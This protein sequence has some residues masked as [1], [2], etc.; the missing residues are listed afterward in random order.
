MHMTK[1]HIAKRS[2]FYLIQK[3]VG[4][5]LENIQVTRK[6]GQ[7]LLASE[8]KIKLQF[9]SLKLFYGAAEIYARL[10]NGGQEHR[11]MSAGGK[12]KS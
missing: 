1:S 11:N 4:T 6:D 2:L 8:C 3:L 5:I 10:P 9:D 12:K 7:D